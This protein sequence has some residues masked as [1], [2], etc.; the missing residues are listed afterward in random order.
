MLKETPIKSTTVFLTT[1]VKFGLVLGIA[2]GIAALV[3]EASKPLNIPSINSAN[4]A[5][6]YDKTHWKL[7]GKIAT[8]DGLLL[9]LECIQCN[10]NNANQVSV[11]IHNSHKNSGEL[12]VRKTYFLTVA[13]PPADVK[14]PTIFDYLQF[15]EE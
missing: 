5:S 3:L 4:I 15:D 14:N 8:P 13:E 11:M 2:A 10:K 6:M 7:N 9:S 1:I 12:T